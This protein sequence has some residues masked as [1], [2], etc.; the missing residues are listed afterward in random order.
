[1]IIKFFLSFAI[2]K[3]DNFNAYTFYEIIYKLFEGDIRLIGKKQG[4][5]VF[6]NKF[7]NTKLS[8]IYNKIIILSII[9][10]SM[11]SSL[12]YFFYFKNKFF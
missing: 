5:F 10:I 11:S 12:Y 7:D 6:G 9:K 8:L 1:M 2:R 4:S 3:I